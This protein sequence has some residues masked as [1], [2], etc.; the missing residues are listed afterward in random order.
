M[1][2]INFYIPDFYHRYDLNI[3]LITLMKEHPE[4]FYDNINIGAVYGTFP[5]A[6]W[7]G[8]R[9]LGGITTSDN[10]MATVESFNDLGVP[11]RFTFT[12]CLL[13]DTHVYDAYCNLI[14][15]H[16]NNGKNEVLVN[17][18]VLEQYLRDKYPDFKYILS[19]T[20]CERDVDKINEACSK[21]DFVVMDYRDNPNDDFLS[22]LTNKDHIEILI[23]AYCSPL[24]SQRLKH[25]SFL[26]DKQLN[27]LGCSD[28]IKCD[29]P[30]KSF[31]DILPYPTVIKV[32]DLYGKYVDMGFSNFKIEGRTLHPMD[33]IESYV[34]YLVKPE[35]KEKVRYDLVRSSWN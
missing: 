29:A 4:Y 7:N 9:W 3:K 2:Q 22:R 33:L 34:Y 6:I 12:N 24:C 19:T 20:R 11:I 5:G 23:N 10:M 28:S 14:M 32:E 27:F 26:A 25:Y 30:Y 1:N 16:A 18:P 15:K 21:Y 8:G 13:E 35:F 17:S 31:F